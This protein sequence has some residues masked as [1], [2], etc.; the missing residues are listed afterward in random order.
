MNY[1]LFRQ[2]MDWSRK[3]CEQ[4]PD[5]M[6]DAHAHL[7]EFDQLD[8]DG[9]PI[10]RDLV[11][12][13]DWAAWKQFWAVLVGERMLGGI[14]FGFPVFRQGTGRLEG[15]SRSNLFLRSMKPQAQISAFSRRLLLVAPDSD[16]DTV[17]HALQ[18]GI[19]SGLKPYLTLSKQYPQYQDVADFLPDWLC[20]LA[21]RFGVP[22]VLHL[23]KQFAIA[24]PENLS[25]IRHICTQ[26]PSVP[27]ILAHCGS[28]FNQWNLIDALPGLYPYENLFFDLSF[29][30]ESAPTALLLQKFG[31]GRLLWGSD[32]PCCVR[33]GRSVSLGTTDFQ[34][35]RTNTMIPEN[36]ALILA[37]ENLR[38]VLLGCMLAGAGQSEKEQLFYGT[39]ASLYRIDAKRE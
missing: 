27:L 24:D 14:F 32:F 22:I 1:Q 11:S 36:S 29:L 15:I 26:Y 30:C 16:P 21:N 9:I 12:D 20:A 2:D 19:F 35:Q 7:Y 10:F 23:G 13:G 39:A 5:K 8:L 4:L 34:I 17:F 28:A 37:V 6:L 31:A 3:I 38:A 25:A 18:S 33:H